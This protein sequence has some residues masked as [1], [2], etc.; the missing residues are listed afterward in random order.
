MLIRKERY[1]DAKNVT[2]SYR[3]QEL[4]DTNP[5]LLAMAGHIYYIIGDAS[6]LLNVFRHLIIVSSSFQMQLN[7]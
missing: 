5:L 2:D 7:R 1:A 6:G 4:F 3:K